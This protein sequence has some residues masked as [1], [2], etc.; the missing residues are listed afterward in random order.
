M[1]AITIYY[2]LGILNNRS[3]FAHGSGDQKSKLKVSAGAHP[4]NL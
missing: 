1:A 3:V 4:T 2:K